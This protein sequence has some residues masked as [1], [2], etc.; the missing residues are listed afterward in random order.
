MPRALRRV[1][2]SFVDAEGVTTYFYRWAPRTP[3]AVIHLVHGLGE[4]AKRYEPLAHDLVAAGYEVWAQDYRGHGQTGLEQWGGDYS[5]LGR[6]GP[7]GLPA[8]LRALRQFHTQIRAARPR[9]PIVLLGHSMGSLLGQILLNQGFADDID[10]AV[11]TGTTLRL[12]GYMNSGDLNA[13]HRH[14]GTTGAEWLS[15]DPAVHHA[16]V[17]N[18]L[19]FPAHTLK[20]FGLLDSARLLGVPKTLSRDIPLLLMVGTDDS[21]GGERGVKKLAAAYLARGVSDVT[22]G[23]YPGARH[24]IF[25]ETNR[26]EVIADLVEWLGRVCP[27]ARK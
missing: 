19:T 7:G 24:E 22:T 4:H 12:P 3:Q 18:P 9:L 14:L 23:V 5:Q 21:L 15:R 27:A 10:G 6:L 2:E 26:E 11:F 16:W 1:D 20:L 25:N 13:R 17:D 8:T